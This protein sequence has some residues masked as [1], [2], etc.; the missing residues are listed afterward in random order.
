MNERLTY[1]SLIAAKLEQ[2]APLPALADDIWARISADLDREMPTDESEAPSGGGPSLPGT[3]GMLWPGLG[4]LLLAVAGLLYWYSQRS[5]IPVPAPSPQSVPADARP[6][7]SL[8][9]DTGSPKGI[10]QQPAAVARPVEAMPVPLADS[11]AA[12]ST[13]KLPPPVLPLPDDSRPQ[14]AASASQEPPPGQPPATAGDKA[15]P[16]PAIDT[17]IK[18]KPRGVTGISNNDYRIVPDKKDSARKKN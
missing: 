2:L 8:P 16:P 6:A 18:K 17:P 13:G 4:A 5:G 15:S 1:E 9:A 10:Y 12:P 3:G 7:S 11:A 14:P